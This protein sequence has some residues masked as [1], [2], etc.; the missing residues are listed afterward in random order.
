MP[1]DFFELSDT[2]HSDM[3]SKHGF[4]LFDPT[5][6]NEE[7]F[8]RLV[9]DAIQADNPEAKAH[10]LLEVANM[11]M[12]LADKTLGAQSLVPICIVMP[13]H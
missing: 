8:I 11:S 13:R 9:T 2:E 4:T 1:G 7:N 12:A 6:P 10:L 3:L 5:I